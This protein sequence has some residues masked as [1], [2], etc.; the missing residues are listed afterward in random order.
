[1]DFINEYRSCKDA[2]LSSGLTEGAWARREK[3]S[4]KLQKT[5]NSLISFNALVKKDKL[6]Y[7]EGNYQRNRS[8]QHLS[9]L[10]QRRAVKTKG[11]D[12]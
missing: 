2:F 1:V 12:L 8:N 5:S 3:D 11:I 9:R 6:R 7:F 4:R 10:M